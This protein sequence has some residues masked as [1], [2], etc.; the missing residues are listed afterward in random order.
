MSEYISIQD[1]ILEECIQKK[2]PVT[3]YTINGFQM[4]GLVAAKDNFV[5]VIE[6]DGKHNMVY[7]NAIST[8]TPIRTLFC[9]NNH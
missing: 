8:L 7:K 3:V 1:K 4:R 2:I 5:V 6:S 9:M